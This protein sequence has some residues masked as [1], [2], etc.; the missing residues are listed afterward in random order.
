MAHPWESSLARAYHHRMPKADL[1]H[2]ADRVFGTPL[3][4]TREKGEVILSVLAERFGIE[5]PLAEIPSFQ[6]REAAS[7][8]VDGGVAVIPVV[9]TLVNKT[10]GMEAMSGMTSYASIGAQL[11]QALADPRVSAILLDVDSPGGECAGMLELAERIYAARSV[12]PI[13]AVA[14]PMAASAAYALAAAASHITAPAVSAVGSIGVITFHRDESKANEARGVKVTA[15]HAGARKADG[16]PH[17]PLSDDARAAL[18]SRADGIYE[19]FVDHV[20]KSRGMKASAVRST[21]AGV[22]LGEAAK[23]NGLV[24]AI[25]GKDEALRALKEGPVKELE[26]ARAEIAT[27]RTQLGEFETTK[28]ELAAVRSRVA[29]FERFAAERQKADDAAFVKRL[30]DESAAIQAPIDAAKI[31]KVRVHLAAGRR[32]FALELGGELLEAAHA[33]SGKKFVRKGEPLGATG[34]KK[35]TDAQAEAEILR[36]RGWTVTLNDDE[37]QVLSALQPVQPGAQGKE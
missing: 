23:A 34:P 7:Y 3:L 11:E 4:V 27:L 30:E 17:A 12:K 15:I 24:D 28:A 37:T 13:H 33:R 36:S 9:G 18:Q 25:G 8:K 16:S 22:F 6:E 14:N 1:H 29:E 26:D 31:E 2:L 20:A 32:E 19:L 5:A 10:S 35:L 21:E